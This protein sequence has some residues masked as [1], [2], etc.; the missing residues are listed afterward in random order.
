MAK[1]KSEKISI[2]KQLKDVNLKGFD[3]MFQKHKGRKGIDSK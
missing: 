3:K 2:G 1:K